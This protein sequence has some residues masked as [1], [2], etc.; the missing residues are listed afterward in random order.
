MYM[1]GGPSE[2][3]ENFRGKP[4]PV[5]KSLSFPV[6]EYGQYITNS[7]RPGFQKFDWLAASL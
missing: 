7:Y 5:A 1:G 2:I 4:R 6:S 3:T